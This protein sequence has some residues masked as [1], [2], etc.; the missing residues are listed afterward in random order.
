[1]STEFV[2]KLA[3]LQDGRKEPSASDTAP[4]DSPPATEFRRVR[5]S[6][7]GG[8]MQITDAGTFIVDADS[9]CFSKLVDRA[10]NC[11]DPEDRAARMQLLYKDSD[12]DLIV[13]GSKE[14]LLDAVESQLEQFDGCLYLPI[15]VYLVNGPTDGKAEP[16]ELVAALEP[17]ARP[18]LSE[19]ATEQ[20]AV[21]EPPS[22]AISPPQRDGRDRQDEFQKKADWRP[23][24]VYLLGFLLLLMAAALPRQP[25][26]STAA[27]HGELCPEYVERATTP[28]P[29]W[30]EQC[31]PENQKQNNTNAG[32]HSSGKT[33]GSQGSTNPPPSGRIDERSDREE[34]NHSTNGASS[35]EENL[36]DEDA[37]SPLSGTRKTS[38]VTHCNS[39]SPEPEDRVHDT[40]QAQYTHSL[41]KAQR[42]PG[43]TNTSLATERIPGSSESEKQ[44]QRNIDASTQ[45]S[46]RAEVG[47]ETSASPIATTASS[48]ERSTE[49]SAPEKMKLAS[50]DSRAL[51]RILYDVLDNQP[52]TLQAYRWIEKDP[53]WKTYSKERLRQ[54]FGLALF[55]C[56][57]SGATAWLRS[58]NWLSYSVPECQWWPGGFAMNVCGEESDKL[59]YERLWL[60]GNALDG[61]LPPHLFKLLPTLRYVHLDRNIWLGGTL[62]EGIGYA[63]ALKQLS[64]KHNMF[65]SAFPTALGRLSR[66]T[67]L[68]LSENDFQGTLPKEAFGNLT[69]LR[70]LSLDHNRFSGWI[71]EAIVSAPLVELQLSHNHFSGGGLPASM[72]GSL[73]HLE[74][75]SAPILTAGA[76]GTEGDDLVIPTELG[77]LTRLHSLDMYVPPALW[78]S[79]KSHKWERSEVAVLYN[80]DRARIGTEASDEELIDFSTL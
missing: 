57:T 31:T 60:P 51:E 10:R 34:L 15:W 27:H 38:D 28:Y 49:S 12:G 4:S 29:A 2:L 64:L 7:I 3:A 32:N 18:I 76:L 45:D 62:S 41:A 39:G 26:Q 80:L 42:S 20:V 54:R 61:E 67:R 21:P 35:L 24:V 78:L 44:K 19:P 56:S 11:F 23:A 59:Q 9:E 63:T 40:N 68:E 43:T 55:Y 17:T 30:Q 16:T 37:S 13:M 8:S 73:T 70:K 79:L 33:S 58:D 46:N 69:S 75:L 74:H 72:L 71:P 48:S 6:L 47:T 1:M 25:S 77:L 5:F 52:C 14:E 65:H 22:E 66:L 50:K 36:S 53:H